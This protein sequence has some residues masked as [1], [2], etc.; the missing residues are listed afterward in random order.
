MMPLAL[1]CS[2]L[3]AAPNVARSQPEPSFQAGCGELRRALASLDPAGEEQITIQ[4]VGTL[5]MVES[6]GALVYLA[7]CAPPDPQV[8]CITYSTGGREIG[9]AVVVTGNY[10]QPG[11][12]HVL[13]DPCLHFLPDEGKAE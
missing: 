10:N 1:A 12:D 5:T 7:L 3:V 11:P 9:D 8:L 4:V 2:V 6:D 13:L